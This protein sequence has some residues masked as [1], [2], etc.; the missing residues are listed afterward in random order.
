L[1]SAWLWLLLAACCTLSLGRIA[2]AQGGRAPVTVGGIS[3]TS[4]F[5]TRAQLQAALAAAERRNAT[6]EATRLRQRLTDGDFRAGDRLQVTLVIDSATQTELVVRDSQRVDLPPLGSLSLRGVLRSEAQPALLRFFQRY[7]RN[8]E[9]RVQ[10]L[11]RIG[12]LGAVAKPGYYSV[13][14]DAPIADAIATAGGGPAPN[15]DLGRV[16][17]RRGSAR[18]LDRRGYQ[19]AARDGL[20]LSDAGVLSG[21]EVRVPERKQRNT[22]Q[23]LQIAFFGISALTSLLFLIRA[24]YN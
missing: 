24:F 4:P 15:A 6:A 3:A 2:G 11:V 19:L 22:G 16:E 7:Y 18:V 20:T 5:A 13:P 14:P 23:I 1:R 21:D 9:V 8:P 17:V 12:V 10:P